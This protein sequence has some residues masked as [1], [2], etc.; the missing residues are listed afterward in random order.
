VLRAERGLFDDDDSPL[1]AAA[2][3]RAFAAEHPE[4]RVEAVK[5]VNHYTLVMGPGAGPDKVAAVIGA[6]CVR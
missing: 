5:G 1:I 6:A 2:D 3:L 4:A